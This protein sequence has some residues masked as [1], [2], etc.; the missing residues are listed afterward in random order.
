MDISSYSLESL[1]DILIFKL[2]SGLV[3]LGY[4][5]QVQ[6]KRE[7]GDKRSGEYV[8]HHHSV[9][10]DS[11]REDSHD[12]RIGGHLRCKEYNRDEYEQRTEHIHEIWHKIDVIVKDNRLQGS[13]LADKVIN[14]LTDVEDDDNADDKKQR[15]KESGNEL[16]DDIYVQFLWSEIK[17]HLLKVL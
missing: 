9:E 10:T 2:Q 14:L 17:L 7:D 3:G 12:F 1:L 13:L 5:K 6:T 8:R 11:T 16:L 4:D 15:H